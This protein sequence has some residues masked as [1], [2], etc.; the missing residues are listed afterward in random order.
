[1][2][3][4]YDGAI[5]ALQTVGMLPGEPARPPQQELRGA[6]YQIN[7]E[8][9]GVWRPAISEGEIV[10]RGQLLGEL[11]D[12]FGDTL[13]RYTAPSRSLVL[14]YWTSSA[15]NADRR[16]HGYDWHSGLVSLISLD[17]ES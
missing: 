10:E 17:D 4:H 15:I 14:Y 5:A 9:S 2:A 7:A 3:V 12:Y 8:R 13:E 11:T 1:M 6:R 16:P